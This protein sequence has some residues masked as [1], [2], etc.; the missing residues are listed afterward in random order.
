M[1]IDINL[2]PEKQ[3]KNYTFILVLVILL[4]T[5]AA[6]ATFLFFKNEQIHQKSEQMQKQIQD[7]KILRA[8]QEKKLE[9]YASS[10]AITELNEAISWTEEL[11][12]PAVTLIRH[13]SELL[14]ERGYVLNFNYSDA[15]AVN[16][17]VQFDTS[18]EAAYYLKSL[19]DSAFIESV[20]LSS[21]VTS[22]NDDSTAVKSLTSFLLPRYIAQ[23]E[24]QLNKAA[25]KD[26]EKKEESES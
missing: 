11:P 23:F 22:S 6:L 21:I 24:L 14:P 2:L 10:S 18:R 17:T 20:N 7:T 26:S 13:L 15:G 1:L 8:I 4:V 25:L 5:G 3:K 16:L 9:D 19:K 12:I